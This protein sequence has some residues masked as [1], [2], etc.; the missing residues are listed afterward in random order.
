M[1]DKVD[2][3]EWL[4]NRFSWWFGEKPTC[5]IHL[6][7]PLPSDIPQLIRLV[8][9]A[10]SKISR[11]T[12][13]RLINDNGAPCY[14]AVRNHRIAVGYAYADVRPGGTTVRQIYVDKGYRGA[15]I[16]LRMLALLT[17]ELPEQQ[18]R[19]TTRLSNTYHADIFSDWKTSHVDE[20]KDEVTYVTQYV[21]QLDS[22]T[23]FREDS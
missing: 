11:K 2:R 5:P 22:T 3:P 18:S 19:F 10:G 12:I 8:H 1:S 15:G 21:Q 6:R 17:L 7:E 14:V 9:D 4:S 13:K 20:D 23:T 16:E